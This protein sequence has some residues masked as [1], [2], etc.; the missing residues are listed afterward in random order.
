MIPLYTW[1]DVERL[2]RS[3]EA[4]PWLEAS[5]DLEALNVTCAP[6]RRADVAKR[7]AEIFGPKISGEGA[8]LDL[9][10]TREA[11][12]RLRVV[13]EESAENG[14]PWP[15]VIRPLW[16]D[17]ERSPDRVEPL[18][19]GSPKLTAFYSYK[20]IAA[21]L[22]LAEA[23]GASVEALAAALAARNTPVC[24]IVDGLE[25][26]LS[27]VPFSADQQRLLKALL[28][29][30]TP[31]VRELRSSHLGIVTFVR[32][33]LA[34]AAITQNFGQFEALYGKFARAEA[35][36]PLPP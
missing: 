16:P 34:Q 29:R 6:G 8:V 26:A 24:L 17:A 18:P 23:A 5:A 15:R 20:G 27:Q 31:Q 12:R 2:L 32:R 13:I 36:A 7:L 14:A 19:E 35:H 9:E 33:D 1:R 25:E 4:P 22:G 11:P 3:Q 10:S 28:Q 21:R 30:F